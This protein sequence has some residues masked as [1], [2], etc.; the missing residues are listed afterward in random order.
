[1]SPKLADRV[2]TRCESAANR[3]VMRRS[4]TARWSARARQA[5]EAQ[6]AEVQGAEVLGDVMVILAD[7]TAPVRSA[8]P[9]RGMLPAMHDYTEPGPA[10]SN[11]GGPVAD[12]T[13]ARFVRDQTALA[14][15]PLVPELRLHLASTV[16]PLWHATEETLATR[17]LDPPYWAFAWPGGQAIA[18]RVLD[19]P[20]LVRGR[21]VLDFA[22]GS[23]LAGIGAGGAGAAAVRAWGV[24][25]FACLAI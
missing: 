24:G 12:A 10:T 16:T 1:M 14:A 11:P 15:P 5:A 13:L 6:G 18:R 3:S 20:A 25:P 17:G 8:R 22:A 21:T 19:Q 2:A 23:G 4:A 9:E 7:W